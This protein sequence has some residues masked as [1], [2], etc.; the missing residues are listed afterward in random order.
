VASSVFGYPPSLA[1]QARGIVASRNDVQKPIYDNRFFD[2]IERG[3]IE[4]ARVVVPL[5][6]QLVNPRSV[7]DVGCGRG[8][9]LSVFRENGVEITHGIDGSYVDPHELLIPRDSF[10]TANLDKGLAIAG[11]YDLAVC[12]EVVEHLGHRAALHVVR[13]LTKAAPI[14]LFSAAL[15][16]QGGTR[17]INEQWPQFWERA[18]SS[19][20]FRRIDALRF[21]IV[22]NSTVEWWYRQNIVLYAS[23][24][25]IARDDAL[26]MSYEDSQRNQFELVYR[27][28]LENLGS[29]RGLV[30]QLRSSLRRALV[31]RICK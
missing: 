9:W 12:L 11:T 4:S 16:G 21:Q 3:S 28:V 5:V 10:S 17:H 22:A 2:D 26:R 20:Q 14:I 31:R 30:R 13:C 23:D 24:A 7:I 6:L 8:A 29:F 15:P 18:F 19:H 1:T 25:A 27:D